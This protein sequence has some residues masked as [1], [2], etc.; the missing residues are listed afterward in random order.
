MGCSQ[1]RSKHDINQHMKYSDFQRMFFFRTEVTVDGHE[2][3]VRVIATT[4]DSKHIIANIGAR[5]DRQYNHQALQDARAIGKAQDTGW[6]TLVRMSQSM[7]LYD[8]LDRFSVD[9][10]PVLTDSEI[11]ALLSEGNAS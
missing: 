10:M 1:T 2:V 6:D 11:D 4:R 5:M 8:I 7:L 9:E 3:N